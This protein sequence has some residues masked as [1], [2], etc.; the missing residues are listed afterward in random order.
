M[1]SSQGTVQ[2]QLLVIVDSEWGHTEDGLDRRRY[3][4]FAWVLTRMVRER[5]VRDVLMLLTDIV[6][7]RP[8]SR[9]LSRSHLSPVL[10]GLSRS[11]RW[12]RVVEGAWPTAHRIWARLGDDMTRI[13][14]YMA[15]RE[16]AGAAIW[17]RCGVQLQ[18]VEAAV[19][20]RLRTGNYVG[21]SEKA[22]L[23]HWA[24]TPPEHSSDEGESMR[25]EHGA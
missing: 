20:A 11:H 21:D 12:V 13:P 4:L 2:A 25:S 14:R 15:Q 16:I 18:L 24:S 1:W 17:E 9:R 19:D 22:I 3:P 6:R 7:R 10:P 5:G 8:W 23:R